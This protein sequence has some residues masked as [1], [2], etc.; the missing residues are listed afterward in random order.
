MSA[1][2]FYPKQYPDVGE[3]VCVK[4][5]EKEDAGFICSLLEYGEIEAFLPMT[6]LSKKRVRSVNNHAR[7]GQTAYF[8]VIR[9][10][11][12]YVDVSKKNMTIKQRQLCDDKY[13]K[14]KNM[15]SIFNHLAEVLKKEP[16][17]IQERLSWPL[18]A[19]YNYAMVGEK[20]ES[21]SDEE[22]QSDEEII[23]FTEKIDHHHPYSYLR[24]FLYEDVPLPVPITEEESVALKKILQQRINVKKVNVKTIVEMSCF[25]SEGID[26]IKKAAS[27]LKQI[28]PQVT[29][30]Y[31]TAP[32]YLISVSCH[33]P[34][35]GKGFV[36]KGI[37]TLTSAIQELNGECTLKGTITVSE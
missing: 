12:G 1:S 31:I 5:K 16:Q 35:E 13:Q 27:S 7:I 14:G 21:D 4:I 29:L 24:E 28:V 8:E 11:K 17:E 25:T 26:A 34:E 15:F 3:I 9:V 32:E 30:T 10:S 37:N 22:L 2:R 19:N 6:E 23:E 36:E 18:Y 20:E 33:D